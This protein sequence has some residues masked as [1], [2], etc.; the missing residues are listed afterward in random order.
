MA[1][2]TDFEAGLNPQLQC[3]CCRFWMER[4]HQRSSSRGRW[5]SG[6]CVGGIVRFYCLHLQPDG[7]R[8]FTR[9]NS[10]INTCNFSSITKPPVQPASSETVPRNNPRTKPTKRMRLMSDSVSNSKV[11]PTAHQ[12]PSSSAQYDLQSNLKSNDLHI[13]SVEVTRP[14]QDEATK[15]KNIEEKVMQFNATLE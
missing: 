2:K 11:N 7:R 9:H 1:Y 4:V 12:I 15:M 3:L 8:K 6:F 13:K 10:S 5:P 14:S